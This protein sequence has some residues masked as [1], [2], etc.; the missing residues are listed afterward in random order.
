MYEFAIGTEEEF[1]ELERSLFDGCTHV[2]NVVFPSQ[3]TPN[4]AIIG[5]YQIGENF[6]IDLKDY[7]QY[8][9]TNSLSLP[10]F[11]SLLANGTIRF[12]SF[13][14]V[15]LFFRDMAI[16]FEP[17]GMITSVMNYTAKNTFGLDD[18]LFQFKF[19]KKNKKWYAWIIRM[20]N[21]KNRDS[22][23]S[24]THRLFDSATNQFYVCWD[25]PLKTLHDVQTVS[26]LWADKIAEYIAT[27]KH[28]G[29]RGN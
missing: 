3:V 16:L 12:M 10:M 25:T 29:G 6:A 22:S 5:I 26:M 28:F 23:L 18:V 19:E 14:D 24:H 21:L 27:G 1:D 15:K 8:S 20:P 7:Q 17:N 13:L 4:M 2:Y 9:L 11:E